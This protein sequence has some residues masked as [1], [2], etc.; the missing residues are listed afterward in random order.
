MAGRGPGT[1]FVPKLEMDKYTERL[2]GVH[3]MDIS[4]IYQQ[5]HAKGTHSGVGTHRRGHRDAGFRARGL[6]SAPYEQRAGRALA[7]GWGFSSQDGAEE[8]WMVFCEQWGL[9]KKK[10]SFLGRR[11]R[12]LDAPKLGLEDATQV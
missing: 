4:T 2:G 6:Q 12:E 10:K 1:G 3:A 9:K 5:K 11:E 7:A 8:I